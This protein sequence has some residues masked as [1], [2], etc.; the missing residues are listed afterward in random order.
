MWG[1][2]MN[3]YPPVRNGV[4]K[5]RHVGM[6]TNSHPYENERAAAVAGEPAKSLG[7]YM[8]EMLEST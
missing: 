4:H 7:D 3:S 6:L 1:S 5:S 8:G 2:L